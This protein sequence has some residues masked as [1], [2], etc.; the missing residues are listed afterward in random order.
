M[1][2]IL[3]YIPDLVVIEPE[4]FGDDRGSFYESYNADKFS[5][6]GINVSF[7]QDNHSTSVKGV[8][9]GLHFQQE[10]KQMAKLVRVTRGRVW[11]CV[12]DLR[13]ESSTFLQWFG[14][15]LSAENKKMLF[16]PEGF[17][18]GFYTLEDCEFLY[19]CS[20]VYDKQLDANVR[21]DDQV[22]G[23]DWRLTDTPILSE[24][25][26][27]APSYQEIQNSLQF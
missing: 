27:R 19:K 3:T 1:R 10:P 23:I 21:F 15:E 7:L 26:Q 5:R 22:F 20:A 17:A 6:L 18:H 24:R 4:V 2:L 8:L 16:V 9:R 12:V 14:I 13:K 11:D 25:D